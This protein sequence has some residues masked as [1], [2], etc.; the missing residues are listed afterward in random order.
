[1]SDD[2]IGYIPSDVVDAAFEK[3][4]KI[5]F[6]HGYRMFILG[7]LLGLLCGLAINLEIFK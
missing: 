4:K 7:L 3:A 5:T 2:E 6:Y 1:M